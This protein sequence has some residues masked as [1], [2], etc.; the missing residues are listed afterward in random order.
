MVS[1]ASI[2]TVSAWPW[3]S[4]PQ[5]LLD[6]NVPIRADSGSPLAWD[7]SSRTL[8][9]VRYGNLAQAAWSQTTFRTRT[10]SERPH[11]G[12]GLLV[13]PGLHL[14]FYLNSEGQ[15]VCLRKADGAWVSSSMGSEKLQT[16]LGVDEKL[17]RVFAYD[18]EAR[19]IR[20]YSPQGKSGA[21][22][23][24]LITKGL[25]AA[26]DLGAVDSVSGV[27]YTTHAEADQSVPRRNGI[28]P[29]GVREALLA[30][31]PLV[32]TAWDGTQ[33]KSQVIA[34]T[35]VPQQPAL[36]LPNGSVYFATQDS[37]DG[38][39]VYSE[40]EGVVTAPAALGGSAGASTFEDHERY[41]VRAPN[42][43]A[44]WMVGGLFSAVVN[45][46]AGGGNPWVWLGSLQSP[47]SPPI[48]I[49]PFYEPMWR[50][51]PLPSRLTRFRAMLNPKQH[52]IVQHRQSVDGEIVVEQ[53][54][55]KIAGYLYR[56][57]NGVLSR[58]VNSFIPN[59]AVPAT[60]PQP[61]EDHRSFDELTEEISPEA[62]LTYSAELSITDRA[63]T[64]AEMDRAVSSVLDG[65]SLDPGSPFVPAYLRKPKTVSVKTFGHKFTSPKQNQTGGRYRVYSDHATS[66]S[67]PSS[68]AVD[69]R[70][71][72]T[73][74]TQAPSPLPP[75]GTGAVDDSPPRASNDPA[76]FTFQAAP[77]P[78][79]PQAEQGTVWIVLVY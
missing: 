50:E 75:Y 59:S 42:Y 70:T 40:K 77:D 7:H 39:S 3:S 57:A 63:F 17:H 65:C 24:E 1:A 10:L 37:L 56:D 73:F 23:S 34:D 13:D 67:V 27:I 78:K 66:L 71:G 76:S 33:W 43:P 12:G 21:W 74:Y 26:G 2:S 61:G 20:L 22:T 11:A 52:R 55:V 72:A 6:G 68:I 47:L 5:P 35:G 25:G 58:Q 8:W 62:L 18:P 69:R 41:K 46:W 31:W 28:V 45:S 32:H 49:I 15:P 51:T 64:S 60:R 48:E 38:M 53:V 44:E 14:V 36:K 54:G 9:F 19:G 30:P 4:V 79:F 16:L 29:L